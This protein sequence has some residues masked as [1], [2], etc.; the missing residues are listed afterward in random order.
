MSMRLTT[1]GVFFLIFLAIVMVV[2]ILVWFLR[3]GSQH[4]SFWDFFESFAKSSYDIGMGL[5]LLTVLI[6][7]MFV[8]IGA[9]LLGMACA[10]IFSCS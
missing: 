3:G 5:V 10:T 2:L 7:V 6:P 9:L 1:E 8:I 4:M